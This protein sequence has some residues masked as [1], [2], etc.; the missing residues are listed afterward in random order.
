MPPNDPLVEKTTIVKSAE[1]LKLKATPFAK[2][3]KVEVT[4]QLDPNNPISLDSLELED[5]NVRTAVRNF[6]TKVI[7]GDLQSKLLKDEA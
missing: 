5:S 3:Y 4:Y 2:G 6:I 7:E 1:P